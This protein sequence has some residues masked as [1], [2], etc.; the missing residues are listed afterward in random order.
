MAYSIPWNKVEIEQHDA[1]EYV[2]KC[3]NWVNLQS[4]ITELKEKKLLIFIKIE[5]EGLNRTHILQRMYSRYAKLRRERESKA[6]FS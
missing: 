6:L 4:H 3:S 1:D 5:K 2:E